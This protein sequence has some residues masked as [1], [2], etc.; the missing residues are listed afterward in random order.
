MRDA[1]PDAAPPAPSPADAAAAPLPSL[2]T[3]PNE[4][5]ARGIPT[6]VL[7]TAGDDRADHIVATQVGMVRDLL[8]A[9]AT[10][11][12]DS[13]DVA[14]GPSAWPPNPVVYGSPDVNS[15]VARLAPVLPLSFGPDRL[16]FGEREFHGTDLRVIAVI[17]A[18]APDAAGP[19]HPEFLLYAGTGPAAV[20]EINAVHHGAE[21]ILIANAFG[22]LQTGRW[23][24]S[25]DG[26]LSAAFPDPPSARI[27]W[28]VVERPLAPATDDGTPATVRFGFP[29]QLAPVDDEAAVIDAALRGLAIA[30]GK[31]S[32]AAPV[33]LSLYVYPDRRSKLSLTGDQGDGHAVVSA[34]V[35]HVLHADPSPDGPLESLVAH[36][37]TH[38]LAYAAWGPPG[39]ALVGEGLAVWA[40]GRYGG[41]TLDE[42]KAR[43]DAPLRLADFLG[44]GFRRTPEATTYPLAGLLVRAAV[45]V[46]G[47][48]NVRDR[49]YGASASTWNDACVAAGTTADAL[50]SAV[51]GMLAR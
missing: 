46:V 49:L 32:L 50:Q 3:T 39:S 38:I 12:D 14:A 24:R 47:L 43:L 5:L 23:E 18:R 34:N 31:L 21:P 44:A 8:K 1:A 33:S 17:P 2:S 35:I 27:A 20:A 26:A 28:R 37:G 30:V 7:G 6:F 42:W 4:F 19:G 16:A 10:V 29:E 48:G 36:E 13:I 15:V 51:D 41:A 40:S 11:L 25:P 22:R 9:S 45:D